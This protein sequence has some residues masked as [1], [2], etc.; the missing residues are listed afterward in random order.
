M[1]ET[2]KMVGPMQVLVLRALPGCSGC[3]ICEKVCSI[4][5][6]GA[7]NPEKA[8]IR[9]YQF[10]PG[11]IDVPIVCQ[12]CEDRPCVGACP[13][14]ALTYDDK[15]F[16]LKVD[17]KL[18]QGKK[19]CGICNQACINA[20]RGGCITFYPGE[21]DYAQ[22]CDLCDGDPE[23]AKYCPCDTLNYMQ[24]TPLAK[25]LAEPSEVVADRLA[26]QFQP[27]KKKVW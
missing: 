11:P 24:S 22:V 17:I 6:Y 8:R 27:A 12:Y 13:Y 21:Q 1:S 4:K 7:I 20:G 5:H 16:Q 2:T 18:C 14:G 10:F 9:V 19:N 3:R 15:S 26:E 23:C 25:R